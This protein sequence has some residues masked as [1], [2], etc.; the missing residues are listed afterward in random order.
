MKQAAIYVRVSTPDQH[1]E[2]QLYELI[3]LRALRISQKT[4]AL[5]MHKCMRGKGKNGRGERI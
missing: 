5:Q 3:A 1:V 2:T 4:F